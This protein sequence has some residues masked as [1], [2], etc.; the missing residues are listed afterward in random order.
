MYLLDGDSWILFC[1]CFV[2]FVK[3]WDHYLLRSHVHELQHCRLYLS[4]W[5]MSNETMSPQYLEVSLQLSSKIE[6][7]M[8]YISQNHKNTQWARKIIK[9]HTKKFVKSNKSIS[10][11]I[12][13]TK[14][15]F[16]RFQ[17][18]PKINFWTGKTTSKN[19]ISWKN[20]FLD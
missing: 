17:K 15:H 20:I 9:V 19:A 4:L 14:F 1:R 13:L 12:F 7:Y 18:W 11:I 2:Y 16:V 3:N 6:I 10:R 5:H 8:S